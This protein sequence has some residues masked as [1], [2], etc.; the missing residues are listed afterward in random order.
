MPNFKK[1]SLN[2]KNEQVVQASTLT[3]SWLEKISLA[4]KEQIPSS[5]CSHK[6]YWMTIKEQSGKSNF[7]YLNPSQASIRMFIRTPVSFDP[8]LESTPATKGWRTTF[9]SIF[10]I[11]SEAM[12]NKAAGLAVSS[13]QQLLETNRNVPNPVLI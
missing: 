8:K 12:L 10:T 3:K 2:I 9:P 1:D 7:V 5:V 4:I 13:Y 6:K 11:S